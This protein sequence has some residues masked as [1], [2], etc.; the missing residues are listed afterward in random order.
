LKNITCALTILMLMIMLCACGND[1]GTGS[2]A[3]GT[4]ISGTYAP[5]LETASTAA[6]TDASE[7][8]QTEAANVPAESAALTETTQASKS[9]GI[10]IDLTA[11]SSTMVYSEVYN[12]MVTPENY[13]GKTVKMR[14]QLEIAQPL[15]ADGNPDPQ[16]IYF[17]CI[18]ADATACCAQGIEFVLAGE[19]KYP[20]DYP[21]PG[22]EITV[23][24][25]F[26]T[27]EEDGYIY[28]QL[29]DAEMQ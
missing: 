17:S 25:T 14:G 9:A 23:S 2:A 13:I 18:I 5:Q 3:M 11:L 28:G 26:R 24:G 1:A 22:A 12:M 7:I 29:Y 6:S 8:A 27:Y 19:H 16:R 21:Q 10:D 20:E 4:A 15:D